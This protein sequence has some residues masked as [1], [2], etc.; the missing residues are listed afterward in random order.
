MTRKCSIKSLIQFFDTFQEVIKKKKINKMNA[1]RFL[2]LAAFIA[3]L[4]VASLLNPAQEG[5]AGG[6]VSAGGKGGDIVFHRGRLI[7]R[8]KKNK[9]GDLV[10]DDFGRRR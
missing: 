3:T 6:G 4:L 9:D 1:T 2:L 7:M 8:G 10:I 5:L